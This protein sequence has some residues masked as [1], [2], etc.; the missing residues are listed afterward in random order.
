MQPSRPVVT[1]TMLGLLVTLSLL[2][3]APPAAAERFVVSPG[4]PNQVVF[5]SKA[6]L[7][8]FQGKTRQIEGSIDLDPSSLGDSIDVSL[9][10]DL[11]SLDTGMDL[12]NKHMRENHLHT[13]R[14]PKAI[15][16]GGRISDLSKPGLAPGESVDFTIQGVLHLHNVE[17][18][19]QARVH[20][21]Q[22]SE[23]SG[24]WLDIEVHFQVSLADFEIPR[25]QFLVMK[26]NDVQELTLRLA[27]RLDDSRASR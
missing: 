7:E 21:T 8:T 12:R 5:E 17:R 10:V 15:F 9:E 20:M 11:A 2:G 6:P 26:L 25:P 14:Y 18:E 1:L 3:L 16:H 19:M 22:K 4:K 24:P 13:D 27:A 23:R